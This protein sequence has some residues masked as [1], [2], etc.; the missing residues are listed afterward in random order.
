ML[1]QMKK[2]LQHTSRVAVSASKTVCIICAN[3][4]VITKCCTCSNIVSVSYI[5]Y[6]VSCIIIEQETDQSS[7]TMVGFAM[8]RLIT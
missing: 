8:R 6:R 1:I 3:A 4:T 2:E 7:Q 5:V